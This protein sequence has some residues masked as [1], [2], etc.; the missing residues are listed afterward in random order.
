MSDRKIKIFFGDESFEIPF[1]LGATIEDA[2]KAL[3][4]NGYADAQNAVGY[5]DSV[6]GDIT[7]S[8]AAGK[9]G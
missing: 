9:K 1:S 8:T 3:V 5:I 7:L 4:Q 2:K 6:T